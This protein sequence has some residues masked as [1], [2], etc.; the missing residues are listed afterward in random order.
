MTV[1]LANFM[2]ILRAFWE[3]YCRYV[4][5][6]IFWQFFNDS[7]TSTSRSIWSN[8]LWSLPKIL[9]EVFEK[10]LLKIL[11][12]IR[13]LRSSTKEYAM[14]NQF[15]ILL[16]TPLTMA[17]RICFFNW[18]DNSIHLKYLFEIFFPLWVFFPKISREFLQ[19]FLYLFCFV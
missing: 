9:P 14:A 11:P 4:L 2:E 1:L 6:Q 5:L 16:E 7:L 15:S 3:K 12:E 10:M 18:S 8:S 19:K 13:S 17:L